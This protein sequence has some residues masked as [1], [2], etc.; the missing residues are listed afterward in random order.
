MADWYCTAFGMNR[1]LELRVE[2]LE[3]DIVMLIHPALGYR[4]ELLRRPT[5]AAGD[6]PADP[7]VAASREGYGHM[8]FDVGDLDADHERLLSFGADRWSRLRPSPEAGVRMAF[9]TDPEGN[10]VELLQRNTATTDST[11]A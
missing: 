3:L 8:A 9:M 7:G 6:K 4:V 1:E 10:L 11:S 2:P 5:T